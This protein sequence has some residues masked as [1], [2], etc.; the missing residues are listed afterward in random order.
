MPVLAM[1]I[2]IYLPLELSVP[3]ALGGVIA[4][5]AGRRY[6]NV[7]ER[8]HGE[9]NGTLCAAGLITGEA[10][11]GI[12][13]AIPIVAAGS[14]EVFAFWGVFDGAWPGVLLLAAV[15]YWLYRSARRT[16]AA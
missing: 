9:R 14:A 12:V 5:L 8:E 10:L 13:M 2:G 11:V 4:A 6:K 15:L 7:A 1:A 16:E 3:I